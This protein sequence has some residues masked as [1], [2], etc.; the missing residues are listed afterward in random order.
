M[1]A[2]YIIVVLVTFL[3]EDLSAQVDAH[4]WSH[5]FG[6]HGLLLN[7][8]VISSAHDETSIYYNPGSITLDGNLGFAFSFISPTYARLKTRNFLG[9]GNSIVDDGFGFSPG[10]LA[11]RFKPFK[12]DKIVA[13]VA[14]FTRL[15]SSISYEDRLSDRIDDTNL[16]VFRSDLDFQ[17][18]KD[19]DWFGFSLGYRINDNLG[20]GISQFSAW[21]GQSL[22]IDLKKEILLASNTQVPIQ[23]WH[24]AFDYNLSV[25]SGWITKWGLSYCD[26]DIGIGLTITSPLYGVIRSGGNYA[27]DDQKISQ[28][29]STITIQSERKDLNQVT[30]RTPLSI[31]LGFDFGVSKSRFFVS[32]E[33]FKQIDNY[34]LFEDRSIP[35]QEIGIE[36]QAFDI[37][38][39]TGNESVFNFA[40]GMEYA[41][42]DRITYLGGFRTDFNESSKLLINNEANVL[43][44]TPNVYHLSG[45][46]L[47]SYDKS[48][49]SIGVDLGYGRRPGG[50]QLT[51]LSDIDENNIFTISGDNVVTSNFYSAS[52]FI[53]YDFIF[54]RISEKNLHSN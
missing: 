18:K 47:V 3:T 10:F 53:T 5:Q 28:I 25:Y 36:D 32:A 15:R 21:H 43:S 48:I 52:L 29:D 45:G 34:F 49:F 42:N 7:G 30:Y 38:V 24:S 6:A 13:G 11:V 37:S 16:F 50:A 17:R 20:I 23:S 44:S 4:Y 1:R 39:E 9:T 33:Y 22:S 12:T 41:K 51:D 26:E 54:K 27:I 31:G 19:E 8:A 40:F 35:F 46:V 14:T 2:V